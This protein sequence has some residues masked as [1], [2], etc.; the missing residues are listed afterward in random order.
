MEL[1]LDGRAIADRESLHDVL[2]QELSLPQ[3][4][5]RNLDALHDLLEERAEDTEITLIHA[6]ALRQTLGCY[7]EK[8]LAV[9]HQAAVEN[10][11]LRI[12]IGDGAHRTEVN[13]DEA[14]TGN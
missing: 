9:L 1:L 5:G 7:G 4:Y 3:Y 2:Q 13:E 11:H 14:C 6:E 12:R 10:P 8:L